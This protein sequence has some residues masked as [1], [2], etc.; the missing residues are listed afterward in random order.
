MRRPPADT[1]LIR[2]HEQAF[3]VATE[4]DRRTA[5]ALAETWLAANGGLT[6]NPPVLVPAT[7]P[8]P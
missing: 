2:L 5:L 7:A 6:T 3:S 4:A 1:E 8:A